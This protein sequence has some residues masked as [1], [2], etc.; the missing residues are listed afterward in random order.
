MHDSCYGILA[1]GVSRAAGSEG[2]PAMKVR[3]PKFDFSNIRAHWAPNKEF[4][5][6]VN[7]GS[8]VPAY[9]EPYLLKV[10][11]K[12]RPLIDPAK[13]KIIEDLDIFIK[14][15]MQ[16]W[17]QHTAFN[18]RMHAL[19]YA[20]LK[21]MEQEYEADYK[22]FLE[23]KSLRFNLAYCEGFE[24][25]SATACELYF[26]DYNELLEQADPEPTNLWRWHLAEEFEHRTVCSDVYH[27][28]YGRNRL[29]AYCCRVYG[30]FYALV[31]IL[32]F[33][34][35]VGKKLLEFDRARM[36]PDELQ[37]SLA[38]DKVARK[39]MGQ[40]FFQFFVMICSPF[41][42]PLKRREPKGYK[43]YLQQFEKRFDRAQDAAAV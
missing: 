41:Y 8:L 17:R 2:T 40:R 14:Q 33:V 39:V 22:R 28:L 5:Q 20:W 13:T 9:V 1:K 27:S 23:K 24:S 10:M 12:A 43:Q 38:R 30:Y 36:T 26:D 25:L 42:E 32:G 29:V 21:P 19:G 35:R 16:H 4:A 6:R 3:Y 37:E 34:S 18:K 15:E 7:A 31:H 11:V